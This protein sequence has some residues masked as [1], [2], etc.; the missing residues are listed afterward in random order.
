MNLSHNSGKEYIRNFLNI[1]DVKKVLGLQRRVIQFYFCLSIERCLM[2][3]SLPCAL[4]SVISHMSCV[5]V[6]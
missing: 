6:C 5:S 1:F 4:S 3:L 2:M